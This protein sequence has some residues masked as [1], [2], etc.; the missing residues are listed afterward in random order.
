M[1]I[2]ALLQANCDKL[3]VQYRANIDSVLLLQAT[4]IQDILPSLQ[5]ELRLDQ[6]STDWAREW[7]S[8]TYTIFQLS[9]RNRFTRSFAMEAIRKTLVWRL[10]NMWPP[11]RPHSLSAVRCFPDDVRDPFGRPIL[12]LKCTTFEAI[13]EQ[14]KPIIAQS[15][16]R[17]R[18]YLHALPTR[19][20]N[21]Q[22]PVLQFVVLL[23]LA[24]L[25][26]QNINIELITWT[27]REVIPRFPGML[28]AVFMINYS[29][30]HSG[31]WTIV[32][33]IL[34]AAALSRV[35]FPTQQELLK[36]FT[37]SSLPEDYGGNLPCLADLEDPLR[38]SE[39]VLSPQSPPIP[40][41]TPT[42]VSESHPNLR[43][44]QSPASRQS[45]VTSIIDIG[46]TSRLN[47]YFGY[48][49]DLNGGPAALRHGRRRKRD[50]VRTLAVLFWRRWRTRITF[51]LGFLALL[52]AARLWI[53]KRLRLAAGTAVLKAVF[54]S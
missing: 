13:S 29:W 44:P 7:L 27:L 4:L 6:A 51:L 33:R 3:L 28:A 35:F 53:R 54:R 31:I 45:T 8:D 49:V 43:I 32:K 2:R 19:D 9:R 11:P 1:D 23:D 5:G 16:E 34:P 17:L 47:P 30:A 39:P 41:P 10:S 15:I 14:S 36:Y 12:L 42:Q 48:P 38:V 26:M 18:A 40:L 20:A 25:S 21:P 52:F 22:E 37:P 24:G 50:L 46:A